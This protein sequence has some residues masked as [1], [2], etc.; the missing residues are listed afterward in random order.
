MA[1]DEAV[2]ISETVHTSRNMPYITPEQT[3]TFS[4]CTRTP[5]YHS[6]AESIAT[7]SPGSD[8]DDE[9]IR[10][11]LASP[12]YLQE[13]DA[14][15]DRSQAYHSVRENLVSS[16]SQVPKSTE[17]RVGLFSSNRKSSPETFSDSEDSSSE[18][19]QCSRKQRAYILILSSERSNKNIPWRM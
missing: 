8:L 3:S 19:Q 1:Q 18:H 4:L 15:A 7:L 16:S 14:S 2:C 11:L 5:S 17:K 10:A 6:A 12:L 13:R 9:Q